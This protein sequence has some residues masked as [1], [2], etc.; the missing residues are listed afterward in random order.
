M[1]AR[2]NYQRTYGDASEQSDFRTFAK[3]EPRAEIVEASGDR[4]QLAATY[5][6]FMAKATSVKEALARYEKET[7]LNAAEVEMVR[8]PGEVF[9]HR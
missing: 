1:P 7:G 8:R 9:A 4:S 6:A 5:R 3:P 2:W